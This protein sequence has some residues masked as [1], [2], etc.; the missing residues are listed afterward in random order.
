MIQNMS[1]PKKKKER[2]LLAHCFMHWCIHYRQ[3]FWR[4]LW[5]VKAAPRWSTLLPEESHKEDPFPSFEWMC[6]LGLWEGK[7]SQRD[8][9]F[10]TGQL[11]SRLEIE[12]TAGRHAKIYEW[13]SKVRRH[14]RYSTALPFHINKGIDD[15][16][17][18][19][20]RPRRVEWVG[21]LVPKRV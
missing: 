10:D 21:G 9:L 7:F 14:V 4:R 17:D 16:C 5:F 18:V 20:S 12:Y 1:C 3:Y 19:I 8:D 6:W 2:F 15:I 13:M 11:S